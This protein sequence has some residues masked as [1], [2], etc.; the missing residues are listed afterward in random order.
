MIWNIFK[1]NRIS[2]TKTTHKE[3]L[4]HF[5]PGLSSTKL[6]W[7]IFKR[8]MKWCSVSYVITHVLTKNRLRAHDD[9]FNKYLCYHGTITYSFHMY[10]R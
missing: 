8:I 7:N 4:D 6:F 10:A 2:A 5:I 9:P 1:H 3:M